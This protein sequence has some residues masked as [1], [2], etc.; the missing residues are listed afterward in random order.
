MQISLIDLIECDDARNYLK[1][2]E[3][4]LINSQI[5]ESLDKIGFA[6]ASLMNDYYQKKG[7]SLVGSPFFLERTHPSYDF[8][9]E[10]NRLKIPGIGRFLKEI[11]D[12]ISKLQ[13][14]VKLNNLGIGYQRFIKFRSLMPDIARSLGGE[15]HH[16]RRDWESRGLPSLIEVR[17]CIDFVIET[18]I[19]LQEKD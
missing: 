8:R 15:Y 2:A 12:S 16:Y 11:D 10:I 17:S 6:F 7:G 9:M 3:K 5:E 18:A 14:A 13:E 1:E 4:F 19:T